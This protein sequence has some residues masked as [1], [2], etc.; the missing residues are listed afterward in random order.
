MNK[1]LTIVFLALALVSC[2]R[3][4][5]DNTTWETDDPIAIESPVPARSISG[6]SLNEQQKQEV[7]NG[8]QFAIRLLQRLYEETEKDVI[9][10]PLS[11]QYALAMTAGGAKGETAQEIYST[12]GYESTGEALNAYSRALIEQ[13]P[14]VD[15]DVALKLA[16]ALVVNNRYPLKD[17]FRRAM[18][19]YYYAAVENMDFSDPNRVLNRINEWAFRNTEGL[20]NPLLEDVDPS[21][22]AYLMNALYFK[23]AWQKSGGT[24]M[25]LTASTREGPFY[26]ANGTL[27]SVPY[28]STCRELSY[29]DWIDFRVVALPYASGKY[30][31]YILMPDKADGLEAMLQRIYDETWWII[32][33]ML[34][35]DSLMVNLR[36]PKFEMEGKYT[37]NATLQA[38]GIN[39]AFS[40][41]ADFSGMFED[42]AVAFCISRVLQKAKIA[43]AE[44]GTEAA[45]VTV[46]EMKATSAPGGQAVDFTV[47]H[48]FAFFIAEQTSG[49]ILFEGVYTG[50]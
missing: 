7:K 49:A 3:K 23:A 14:A 45:A 29:I 19:G 30:K 5:L 15:L 6:V 40:G 33:E 26:R 28:M 4:S 44:W 27:A 46:V 12:L 24:P 13:L 36:L 37:L 42:P 34:G 25:F 16:D 31:M 43:V 18:Q 9:C 47:D 38:L 32:T 48:P 41:E 11:L 1:P 17:S 2:G 20:I 22:A 39:R 50:K 10:S 21:A 8:N 35:D